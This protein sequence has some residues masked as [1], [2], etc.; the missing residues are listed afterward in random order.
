MKERREVGTSS[1]GAQFSLAVPADWNGVTLLYSS[2]YSSGEQNAPALAGHALTERELLARGF[3]L[4][5][6]NYST[7]GW[8][9]EA[10]LTDQMAAL[11]AARAIIGRGDLTVAWGHSMGGLITAGIAQ[12]YPE[13]I[14]A[15]VPFCASVAGAIPML[16][17]GL[18]GGFAF[19]AL[20]VPD[21]PTPLVNV[22][23][24]GMTRLGRAQA[25]VEYA[26][27]SAAGRARVALAASLMQLPLWTVDFQAQN[28]ALPPEPSAD[29]IETAQDLQ[30]SVFPLAAYSPR[31]ELEERAGGNFSWNAGVDYRVQLNISGLRGYVE[32]SYE[33]AGIDLDHDLAVL[34]DAPRISADPGAVSYMERN[35]TPTGRIGVPVLTVSLTGDFAPTVS[36]TSAYR[37]VVVASG[38][39]DRL[40][41]IFV[42][43]PG[44]CTFLTSEVTTAIGLAVR[45]V[46]TGEWG[47]HDAAA[48]RAA[49]P[50]RSRFVDAT[51][52]DHVRPYRPGFAQ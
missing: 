9:V 23:E 31:R 37:D 30:A 14:D 42:R 38:N 19:S 49:E 46:R 22:A 15:A 34:A 17:Q 29:D 44:H 16:N 41:Q 40:R 7:T 4:V 6:S 28:Q 11:E 26:R 5:G 51:P 47:A 50:A 48:L 39:E 1:S 33:H 43:S 8:A 2:G 36:Q 27:R 10:A 18:D 35:L 25:M 45:R 20:C 12:E 24:D 13:M 3:A 21:D 52:P 32:Q